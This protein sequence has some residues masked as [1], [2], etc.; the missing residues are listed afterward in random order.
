MLWA[1]LAVA[2][3]SS[4]TPAPAKLHDAAI[5]QRYDNETSY[6]IFM[7]GTPSE[8]Q[9]QTL[10][11]QVRQDAAQAH[12]ALAAALRKIHDPG[13]AIANGSGAAIP[14]DGAVTAICSNYPGTKGDNKSRAAYS[15]GRSGSNADSRSDGQG[16]LSP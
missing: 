11:S 7:N 9:I 14:G 5:C 13:E 15:Y 4:G 12:P 16:L 2:A 6:L 8:Q 3:C 10:D 1:G